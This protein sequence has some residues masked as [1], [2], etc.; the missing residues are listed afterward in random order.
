M[1]PAG[2]WPRGGPGG[3]L[4]FAP[5]ERREIVEA[6]GEK[7]HDDRL[8]VRLL[9]LLGEAAARYRWM[10]DHRIP[11]PRDARRRVQAVRKT[12]E[13]LMRLV[14][15]CGDVDARW[16]MDESLMA[17]KRADVQLARI[18]SER[19]DRERPG[20]RVPWTLQDLYHDFATTLDRVGLDLPPTGRTKERVFAVLHEAATG[21]TLPIETYRTLKRI[22]SGTEPSGAF[23][24]GDW[25][26]GPDAI[27][28]AFAARLRRVEAASLSA[29]LGPAELRRAPVAI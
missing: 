18:L 17:L 21:R 10:E 14:R 22:P 7:A 8:L 4:E 25:Q 29:L 2:D 5:E 16:A 15:A 11:P 12:I 24:F 27:E 1:T 26:R 9:V 6:L 23:L 13:R 19:S 3:C 28:R 20:G